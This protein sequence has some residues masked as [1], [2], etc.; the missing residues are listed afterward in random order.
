MQKRDHWVS[1]T[2]AGAFMGY[3]IGSMLTEQQRGDKGV[4]LSLTPRSV[5]ADWSFN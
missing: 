5:V 2:V 3:A 4:R 1:D